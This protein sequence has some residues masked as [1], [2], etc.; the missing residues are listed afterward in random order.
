[1][2]ELVAA[3]QAPDGGWPFATG[4]QQTDVD[5]AARCMEF[6]RAADPRRYRAGLERASAYLVAMAAPSGGFPT[7]I[8]SDVPDLD[9]T[10]GAILAL[11]P[12][13]ER[14]RDLLAA[15]TDFVLDSQLPDGAFE[16]SWT[17]SESSAILR[18]VDALDAV[19]APSVPAA[20]RIEEAIRRAVKHLAQTQNA[21]G[22]WGRDADARSDVLS[23]AQAVPVVARHGDATG[24]SRALAY[25]LSKQDS[26]GGFSSVPDQVGPRPLAFD[27]PVL[28][29][30]HVLSAFQRARNSRRFVAGASAR[31]GRGRSPRP[32]G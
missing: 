32:V 3:G 14:H 20:R 12:D 19:R 10:A 4:M 27:F 6:L 26:D 22:G 29:D 21:D 13:A 31:R 8:A 28:A 9:M 11:A 2:S 1:M 30:I 5:T 7:W 17:I 23:T 15:A 16:R 24:A 25:L 18:V